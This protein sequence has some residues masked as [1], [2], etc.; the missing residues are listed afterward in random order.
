MKTLSTLALAAALATGMSGAVLLQP[1]LAAKKEEPKSGLKLSQEFVKAA[2]PAQDALAAKNYAGADPLIAAA[3]AAAK[4]DDEKYV[5]QSMRFDFARVMVYA[6]HDANPS[7]AVNEAP[8][9]GPI[10]ALLANPSTPAVNKP[11]LYYVRGVLSFNGHQYPQAIDYFSKARQL[12]YA[13]NDIDLM[14]AK[15]KFDSGDVAGGSTDLDL[16]ITKAKAT[17]K[18]APEDYYRY[19][20]A[21]SNKAKDKALTVSW[22][23]KYAVAYP[24][25]QTWHDVLVTYGLSSPPVD[26]LDKAQ[27]VDLFR[28][29]HDS[30]SLA[31]QSL[32][33]QYAQDVIDRGLPNEALAVIKEGQA[34][35]K[36]TASRAV[37]EETTQATTMSRSEGSLTPL[38]ARAKAS[39]D[40]KLSA[41]TAD[42]YLGK[43]DNAKAAELYRAAL[44]KGGVNADEVN[45]HLGIS[46][47]R[48]GDKAGAVAAFGAVKTGSRGNIASL[49]S[50]WVSGQA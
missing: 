32:Y 6:P 15:A 24:T 48:S 43:G 39:G 49:W 42:A 20:I 11:Q 47:A 3:E 34:T 21:R 25:P 1:A 46:L 4:N 29:M 18:P 37:T 22:L 41:Q 26:T 40:G 19:A 33:E 45:T 7:A 13:N 35:G 36:L 2:K 9:A 10:D 50:M 27:R 44:T 31:D 17:G 8:L 30:K 23:G 38:E 5:A 12:G 16:A 28:L 14:I